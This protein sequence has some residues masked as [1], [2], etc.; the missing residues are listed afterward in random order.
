ME[1]VNEYHGVYFDLPP[2]VYHAEEALSASGCVEL[3]TSK[4]HYYQAFLNP[5]REP[6]DTEALRKGTRTHCYLL[7][8]DEF[9]KRYAMSPSIDKRTVAWKKFKADAEA[10][11]K[12]A[13]TVD[14]QRDLDG[15][16]EAIRA[17][18]YARGLI[19]RP[20][21]RCEVSI[22]WREYTP[23]GLSYRCKARLDLLT[24]RFIA[25]VKTTHDATEGGFQRTAWNF[26]YDVR[27]AWYLRALEAFPTLFGAGPYHF[28]LIAIEPSYP[29]LCNVYAYEAGDLVLGQ[30][31]VETAIARYRDGLANG[32]AREDL[33]PIALKLPR[34]V[35][36][37]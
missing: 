23:D 32:W 24:D 25:D 22:F 30:R 37:T 13:Y 17:H 36:N 29:W 7:E 4:W 12:E 27:A 19:E 9:P 20:G 15:M 26:R 1:K 3:L 8:P 18:P 10:E 34:W 33:R 6:L 11:G 28:A 35:Q 31:D 2:E 5:S 14:E 21:K 16:R